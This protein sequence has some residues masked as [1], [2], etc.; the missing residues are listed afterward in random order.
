MKKILTSLAIASLLTTG[1]LAKSEYTR[2]YQLHSNIYNK[3]IDIKNA[4]QKEIF[5]GAKQD[6]YKF[7]AEGLKEIELKGM[8][9]A[10]KGAYSQSANIAKGFLETAGKGIAMG[11]VI[12][13]V[14]GA[15]DSYIKDARKAAE[16]MYVVEFTTIDGKMTTGSVLLSSQSKGF[17]EEPEMDK[18]KE[19]MKGGF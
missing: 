10:L 17:K 9:G 8:D 14:F 11:A 15:I 7:V 3:S 16:Y 18:I 4:S 13:G 19:I 5:F 1:L 2:Y 6:Y 12:G